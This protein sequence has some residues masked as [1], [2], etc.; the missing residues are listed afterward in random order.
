MGKMGERD[1]AVAEN[2]AVAAALL[3]CCVASAGG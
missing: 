3:P 1:A 2:L